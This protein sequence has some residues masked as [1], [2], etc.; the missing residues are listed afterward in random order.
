MIGREVSKPVSI[1]TNDFGSGSPW[2]GT[3]IPAE[4]TATIAKAR[5]LFRITRFILN[6]AYPIQ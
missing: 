4:N 2:A 1:M 5:T 3:K 6:E